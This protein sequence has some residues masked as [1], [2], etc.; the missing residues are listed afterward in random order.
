MGVKGRSGRNPKYPWDKW[1]VVGKVT[2][3]ERGRDFSGYTRAFVY[4]VY[5]AAT[6]YDVKVSI[7]QLSESRIEVLCLK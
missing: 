1:F 2:V 4:S 6:K 7:K 5:R 3:L